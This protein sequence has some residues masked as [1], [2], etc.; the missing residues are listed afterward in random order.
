MSGLE[1]RLEA[2]LDI[3]INRDN[4]ARTNPGGISTAPAPQLQPPP[5]SSSSR[6]A[7]ATADSVPVLLI[8]DAATDAG[9]YTPGPTDAG[10]QTDVM[11]A[12]LVPPAT[13]RSMMEM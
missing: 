3:I 5:P 12:G 8:R 10:L 6:R 7:S 13:A 4:G 1:S 9:V 2:K 11:A